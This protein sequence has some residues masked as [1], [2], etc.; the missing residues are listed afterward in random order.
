[1][2]VSSSEPQVP[3]PKDFGILPPHDL[4]AVQRA[5]EIVRTHT[6]DSL[7]GFQRPLFEALV[8]LLAQYDNL[9]LRLAI[10]VGRDPS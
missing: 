2:S 6:K 9:A 7:N 3:D 10:I 4:A 8:G 5:R 1:M